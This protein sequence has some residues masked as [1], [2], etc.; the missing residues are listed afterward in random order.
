[1]H[2]LRSYNIGQLY[3]NEA[4]KINYKKQRNI[5]KY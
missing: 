5:L 2:T 3:R 4:E 1:M